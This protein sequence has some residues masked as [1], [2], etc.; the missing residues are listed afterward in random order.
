[1]LP[2]K[3]EIYYGAI[4][5]LDRFGEHLYTEIKM[6]TAPPKVLTTEGL[7]VPYDKLRSILDSAI[8][9]YGR[10][11]QII[12]YKSAPIVDEE[13]RAVKEVVEK[14]SNDDYRIFYISAHVKSGVIYRAYDPAAVD[15]SIRR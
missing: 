8:R 4:Q 5:L 12:L 10:V 13:A 7:F 9:Q 11:P 15:H 1:M 2:G 14:H 3:E 6:F